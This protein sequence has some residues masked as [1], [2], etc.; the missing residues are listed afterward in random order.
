MFHELVVQILQKEKVCCVLILFQ[1]ISGI[2]PS[3]FYYR[4]SVVKTQSSIEF[5]KLNLSVFIISRTHIPLQ[6]WSSIPH[7]LSTI[8]PLQRR[9]YFQC[10]FTLEVHFLTI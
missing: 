3:I 10:F 7:T 4:Y 5:Q 9:I 2:S 8:K 1:E 6:L